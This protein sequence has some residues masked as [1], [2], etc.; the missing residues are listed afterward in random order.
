MLKC[1]QCETN[2][3]HECKYWFDEKFYIKG[4]AKQL[5]FCSCKC[6]SEYYEKNNFKNQVVLK[7]VK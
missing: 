6:G 4:S 2:F 1:A 7:N 3:I 5:P